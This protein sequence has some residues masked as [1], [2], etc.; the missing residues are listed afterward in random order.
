MKRHVSIF[1]KLIYLRYF[2]YPR[3]SRYLS[4]PRYSGGTS[5]TSCKDTKSLR[6][7]V[8][9][10]AGS[11]SQKDRLKNHATKE[12]TVACHASKILQKFDIIKLGPPA[13]PAMP[14]KL[15]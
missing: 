6:K 8:K 14:A 11:E 15:Q 10:Y 3:R 12:E 1:K 4:Y 9:K 13:F 7:N 2:E 5:G